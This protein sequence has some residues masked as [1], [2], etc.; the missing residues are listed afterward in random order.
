MD[1]CGHT[2]SGGHDKESHHSDTNDT[3]CNSPD[4]ETD[5]IAI[6]NPPD[7]HSLENRRE[8]TRENK[9]VKFETPDLSTSQSTEQNFSGTV[10][11]SL[12][13]RYNENLNMPKIDERETFPLRNVGVRAVRSN[14]TE[15]YMLP[16]ASYATG[17]GPIITNYPAYYPPPRWQQY[18]QDFGRLPPTMYAVTTPPNNDLRV[19][20]EMQ[21]IQTPTIIHHQQEAA[22]ISDY[23]ECSIFTCLCCCL[24]FGIIAIAMSYQAKS[25]K[26]TNP[27]AAMASAKTARNMVISGISVGIATIVVG[28]VLA[29]IPK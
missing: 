10:G 14:V 9:T 18:P 28:I 11:A 22:E 15:G 3:T 24:F 19:A 5:S 23:M 6:K 4:V 16:S 8:T 25:L 7:Y 13:T 17:Y 12:Q 27:Q 29:I 20:G 26:R 1:D 2:D 21:R